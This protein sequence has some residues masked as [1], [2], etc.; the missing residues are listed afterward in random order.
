MLRTYQLNVTVLRMRVLCRRPDED[1]DQ[2]QDLSRGDWPGYTTSQG[3]PETD[4]KIGVEGSSACPKKAA[5]MSVLD[6]ISSTCTDPMQVISLCGA[7]SELVHYGQQPQANPLLGDPSQ[8]ISS[9]VTSPA[10]ASANTQERQI[11]II[12]W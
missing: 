12:S 7:G 9:T 2:D 3:M 5:A 11:P 10:G 1:Q 6:P 8:H 4:H